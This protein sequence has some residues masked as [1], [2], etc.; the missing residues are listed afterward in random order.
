MR[1]ADNRPLFAEIADDLRVSA[2]MEGSV[3]YAGNRLSVSVRLVDP[4]TG[5]LLWSSTFGAERGNVGELFAMQTEIATGI[6]K[7]LDR[8]I[9]AEE[10]RR[11]AREATDSA[12]AYESYLR[13]LEFY[14]RGEFA[15]A[16]VNLDEAVSGDSRFVDALSLRG[17]IYAFAQISSESRGLLMNDARLRG[18]SFQTLA[19]EDADRALDL[20]PDAGLALLTRAV[21]ELFRLRY[22]AAGEAFERARTA[23]PRNPSVLG[24]YAQYWALRGEIEKALPLIEQALQLD[25]NGPLTLSTAA[26]VFNTAELPER[27]RAVTDEGLHEAPES[28]SLNVFALFLATDVAVTTADAAATERFAELAAKVERLAP[29]RGVWALMGLTLQ[30]QR[31]GKG[32][33][34]ERALDRYRDFAASQGVGDADWA[35]YHIARDDSNAAY[36]AL[37]RAVATYTRGDADPGFA[38]MT[39]FINNVSP[40][41]ASPL[42]EPRFQVLLDSAR[43]L[44]RE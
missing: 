32:L 37:E 4:D 13:A 36:E 5:Q 12:V 42:A 43:A 9:T 25:P 40:N 15:D 31:L 38:P 28:L 8:E 6:A 24:Q 33:E 2:I 11:V 23:A 16:I 27:V 21:N 26:S 10:R 29:E 1:Y 14:S 20:D 30:Y 17:Y 44:T 39:R 35:Q 19:L 18:R 41:P 22:R 3:Q 7:A 34:A